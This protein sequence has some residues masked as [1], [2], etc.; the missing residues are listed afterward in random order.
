[1]GNEVK[2]EYPIGVVTGDDHL[3]AEVK[4]EY[5]SVYEILGAKIDAKETEIANLVSRALAAEVQLTN[6]FNDGVAACVDF[7]VKFNKQGNYIQTAGFFARELAIL[8][9][10]TVDMDIVERVATM[11][12]SFNLENRPTRDPEMANIW[13]EETEKVKH[14]YRL[15]ADLA[16]KICRTQA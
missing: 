6:E 3:P 1:M 5:V 7:L 12:W 4:D 11:M 15:I 14:T 2:N 9:P 13:T 16:I 10:S 8:T